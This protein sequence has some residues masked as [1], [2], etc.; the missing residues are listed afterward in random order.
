MKALIID[1]SDYKIQN[2]KSFLADYAFM[3]E[4]KVAKSFQ[5]GVHSLIEYRPDLVL[6]DMS[7]PT[8]E[9]TDG[10]LEGRTRIYGGKEIMAEMQFERVI[11]KVII[12][13]QFDTFGKPPKSITLND[14]LQQIKNEYPNLYAGGVFYNNVDFSWRDS[15]KAILT[16][17]FPAIL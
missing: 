1:D 16:N 3:S 6:L 9:R 11:A 8:S 7:L 17:A 5:T 2:L 14:L 4:L 12:I 13:T 10:E 15:L